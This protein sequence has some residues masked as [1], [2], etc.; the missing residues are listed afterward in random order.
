MTLLSSLP[1]HPPFHLPLPPSKVLSAMHSP[2][3]LFC[4]PD[5]FPCST[6]C[7][8][9]LD[10][11]LLPHTQAANVSSFLWTPY[12]LPPTL[13]LLSLHLL[14]LSPPPSP[15]PLSSLPPPLPLP[16][17]ARPPPHH[18]LGRQ[19]ATGAQAVSV[20][21][22]PAGRLRLSRRVMTG[23]SPIHTWRRRQLPC[24]S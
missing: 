1:P 24:I 4:L 15:S 7:C 18:S 12:S 21:G 2:H 8:G 5:S 10:C 9:G 20:G 11:F 17:P 19:W 6:M 23:R 16:L 13:Y 22:T 14:P 3:P